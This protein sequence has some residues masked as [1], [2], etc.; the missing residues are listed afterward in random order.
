MRHLEKLI[1]P[2]ALLALALFTCLTP[3]AAQEAPPQNPKDN[4]PKPA[5]TAVPGMPDDSANPDDQANATP[6]QGPPNP[7]AGA[8]KAVGTGLPILGTPGSPLRWGDFSISS[9]QYVGIHDRFDPQGQPLGP[10]TNLHLFTIGLM[11][12]HLI[13]RT[14]SP[15]ILQYLPQAA[16]IDGQFH[17]NAAANNEVSLGTTFD[18]SQR[19]SVTIQDS[20]MDVHSNPLIPQNFLAAD[21]K[22]GALV[23][24]NFLDTAGSFWAETAT[25]TVQYA[26]TPRTTITFTPLYRYAQATNNQA[27]YLADGQAVAGVATLGYALSPHRTIGFTESYQYLTEAN[28]SASYE[29]AGL[30][31]S[32]Q[33]ARSLWVTGNFGAQRQSFSDL[34]NANNWGFAGGFS[35]IANITKKIPFALAYT[36][37]VAFNNYL[38]LQKA[39]RVDGSIGF[40]IL[41]RVSWS[42]SVGY[43][44]ELGG[45]PNTQGKYGT[46]ELD[47]RFYG[48]FSLFSIFAY[49]VTSTPT[50]QLFSGER[51]T[52]AFGLRWSPP[53][54]FGQ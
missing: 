11:Y 47:Y 8:I 38:S 33:L 26:L 9:F 45:N 20:F 14:K 4:P 10:W 37:G 5:G 12:S 53:M 2:V 27:N 7:Y 19:L 41:P 32:E 30:F 39:D 31:Y 3:V 17:A 24:N 44:R 34:Q 13:K 52:L 51:S 29:T 43:L 23:Q 18:L 25:A 49:T 48:N 6:P 28:Q 42:N 54:R 50:A 16:I 36:R 35:I 40:L 21:G 22:E 46:T 1:G 15:I